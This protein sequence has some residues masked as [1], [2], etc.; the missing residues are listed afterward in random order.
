[1]LSDTDKKNLNDG[2]ETSVERTQRLFYVTCT[3]A[4]KSL[5]VVMYT[6]NAEKVKSEVIDRGW[7]EDAEIVLI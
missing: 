6:N 5:A 4:K 1:M 3:R 7:F 2:K